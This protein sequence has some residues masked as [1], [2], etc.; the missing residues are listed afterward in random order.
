MGI[1]MQMTLSAGRD[2]AANDRLHRALLHTLVTEPPQLAALSWLHA[3]Y[4]QARRPNEFLD[5]LYGCC[6]NPRSSFAA[7]AK[8]MGAS[9]PEHRLQ[10]L[11]LRGLLAHGLLVHCLTMRHRVDYGISSRCSFQPLR[12]LCPHTVALFLCAHPADA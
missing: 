11:T 3:A 2:A 1:L 5:I 7:S 10:L 12:K 9:A 8:K 6:L 4:V